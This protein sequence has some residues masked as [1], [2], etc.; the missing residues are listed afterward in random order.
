MRF[1]YCLISDGFI[2]C[3]RAI[4]EVTLEESN[5][6]RHC[7]ITYKI[8]YRWSEYFYHV[9]SFLCTYYVVHSGVIA[10][11]KDTKGGRQT[12]LFTALDLMSNSKA[13][14]YEDVSRISGKCFRMPCVRSISARLRTKDRNVG[15]LDLFYDCASRLY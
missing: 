14:E 4:R 13:D 2:H 11:G 8:P 1:Q 10:G 15:K 5:W 9:G 6:I 12:V 7:L 3:M